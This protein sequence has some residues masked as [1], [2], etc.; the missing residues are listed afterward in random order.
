[1]TIVNLH[2]L[3]GQEYQKQFVLK[4]GKVTDVIRAIDCNRKG[5]RQRINGLK[6]EGLH[7]D[8]IVNGGR[9]ENTGSVTQNIEQVDLVPVIA[10]AVSAAVGWF[11]GAGVVGL[12]GTTL[13]AATAIGTAVVY[14]VGAAML[15]KALRPK[16]EKKPDVGGTVATDVTAPAQDEPVT[17]E[18]RAAAA[19]MLFNNV[20]NVASQGDPVPLGYGRLKL[21]TSVIQATVKSFP[22]S[23]KT[24]RAFLQ[25]PF[26]LAEEEYS[27]DMQEIYT[28]RDEGHTDPWKLE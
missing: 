4:V 26:N 3:L 8:I 25:N 6:R 20:A 16:P 14:G 23:Q 13:L 10:G 5:F 27:T 1:M 22:M 18:S 21:G 7:Y 24:K 17:L 15:S 12:T 2:G 11:F 28:A 19:S 9:R